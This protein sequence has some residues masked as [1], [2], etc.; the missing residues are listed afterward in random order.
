MKQQKSMNRNVN[1]ESN[2]FSNICESSKIEVSPQNTPAGMKRQY[3]F[4]AE[5]RLVGIKPLGEDDNF[6]NT[7]ASTTEIMQQYYNK[8]KEGRRAFKYIPTSNPKLALGVDKY[9]IFHMETVSPD[10]QQ[11]REEL[12]FDIQHIS[13][14]GS[15]VDYLNVFSIIVVDEILDYVPT[16]LVF[17]FSGI[18]ERHRTAEAFIQTLN[19]ISTEING[20]F[21]FE[22]STNHLSN[23]I[24]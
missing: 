10:N 14:Y 19:C 15:H 16:C 7:F 1:K 11:G 5:A 21:T 12:N 8:R 13:A 6:F 4:S 18:K 17:K 9:H 24:F 22:T 3:Y 23:V 20:V 2:L